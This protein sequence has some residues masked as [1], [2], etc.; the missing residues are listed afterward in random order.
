MPAPPAMYVPYRN[1]LK[2]SNY[3]ADR[4]YQLE[5]Q[6]SIGTFSVHNQ[7]QTSGIQQK[8]APLS[9]ATVASRQTRTGGGYVSPN[10]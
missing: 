5:A 8:I 4:Y 2:P 9:A 6:A 10:A 3:I 1:P 7:V